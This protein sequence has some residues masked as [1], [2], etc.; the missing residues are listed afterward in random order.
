MQELT[1]RYPSSDRAQWTAAGADGTRGRDPRDGDRSLWSARD[2]LGYDQRH[3]MS[4]L[5]LELTSPETFRSVEK[6]TSELGLD[7]VPT[8]A[9]GFSPYGYQR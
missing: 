7:G 4:D 8:F 1:P 5:V 2:P 9:R 6:P 3:Y